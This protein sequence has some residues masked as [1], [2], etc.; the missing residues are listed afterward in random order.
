[1]GTGQEK[2]G[3]CRIE[4]SANAERQ[5]LRLSRK[6]QVR[7]AGIIDGLA[8]EP[9]ARGARKLH[10]EKS[11]Y[12]IRSGDLRVIYRIRDDVLLVLVLRIADRKEAYRNLENLLKG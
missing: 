2:G 7:V 8:V 6:K 5:F 10:A 3:P 11:L 12:R 1:M 4:L 9:R